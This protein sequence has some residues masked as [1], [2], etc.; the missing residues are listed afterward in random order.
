MEKE[1]REFAEHSFSRIEDAVR[2]L[3]EG[4]YRYDDAE[5]MKS[6]LRDLAVASRQLGYLLEFDLIEELRKH[7]N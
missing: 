5:K 6:A 7:G 3:Q 2:S 1:A 4:Y